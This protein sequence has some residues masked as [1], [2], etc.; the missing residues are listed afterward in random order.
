MASRTITFLEYDD[1]AKDLSSGLHNVGAHTFKAKLVTSL[2]AVTDST[3]PATAAY[4]EASGTGYT[5]GG[6]AVTMAPTQ[7][8]GKYKWVASIPTWLFD[9]VGFT[10]V[11][12]VLYNVTADRHVGFADLTADSGVTPVTSADGDIE[13]RWNTNGVVSVGTV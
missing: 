5:A 13:I 12:V 8:G 7:E 10:C 11:A 1:F 6:E 9:S 4:S 2:P 3:V